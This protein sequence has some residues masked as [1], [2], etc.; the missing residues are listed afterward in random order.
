MRMADHAPRKHM[1]HFAI[2]RHCRFMLTSKLPSN[3]QSRF[4]QAL[5]SAELQQK[6]SEMICYGVGSPVS[7]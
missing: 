7:T 5:S 1:V 6:T 4:K 3:R 2:C